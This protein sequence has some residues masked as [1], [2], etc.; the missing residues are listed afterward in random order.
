MK[1][2]ITIEVDIPDSLIDAEVPSW[3]A[4]DEVEDQLAGMAELK[5]QEI[6]MDLRAEAARG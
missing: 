1:A 2:T 3:A 6:I 4:Y 5:L